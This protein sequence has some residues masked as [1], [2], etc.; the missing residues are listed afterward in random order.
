VND[1]LYV[2]LVNGSPWGYYR[3]KGEGVPILFLHGFPDL[4]SSFFPFA[5][6]L[7]E[8]GMDCIFPFLRGYPPSGSPPKNDYTLFSLTRDLVSFL[9]FLSVKE[10]DF[11]GHDWGG[12]LGYF[13]AVLYPKRVRKLMIL[14]V[15]PPGLYLKNLLKNPSQFYRSRYIFFF[16]IP[17][18][19]ELFIEKSSYLKNLILE[20][21]RDLPSEEWIDGVVRYFQEKKVGKSS[22]MYYRHLFLSNPRIFSNYWKTVFYSFQPVQVPTLLVAGDR[23]GGMGIQ[24]FDGV[25]RYFQG[26]FLFKVLKGRG[27][28]LHQESVEEVRDLFLSFRLKEVGSS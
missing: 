13:L 6:P 25:E 19:P 1:P 28:F 8:K 9:D 24:I 18:L 3:S 15:P 10:V 23:D 5:E 4:P 17:F 21:S 16:Q 14:S 2:V 20:W 26:G 27:H 7:R 12:V 22:L 11:V